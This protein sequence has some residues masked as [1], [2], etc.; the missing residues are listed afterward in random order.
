[1]LDLKDVF[2]A[3]WDRVKPL[4]DANP[5]ERNRRLARRASARLQ[6]PVREWCIA[7]RAND[8]RLTP[9]CAAIVPERAPALLLPHQVYVNARLLRNLSHPVDSGFPHTTLKD[10]AKSLGVRPAVVL[11][12]AK[13]GQI[14]LHR[15]KGFEHKNDRHGG[16][17]FVS[18]ARKSLDPNYLNRHQ[19]PDPVWGTWWHDFALSVPPTFEQ[20]VERIPEWH[21]DVTASRLDTAYPT[22]TDPRDCLT[23]DQPP[24]PRA[25]A[26]DPGTPRRFWGWRWRC[27]ACRQTCRLLFYPV[28]IRLPVCVA[29]YLKR[30]LTRDERDAA[31]PIPTLACAKCHRVRGGLSWASGDAWNHIITLVSAGLLYGHE[32]EI[33][34]FLKRQ[35]KFTAPRRPQNRPS[36]KRNEVEQ[37]LLQNLT[38]PQIARELGISP[39]TVAY[40]ALAAR[41]AHKVQTRE[42]LIRKLKSLQTRSHPKS[43]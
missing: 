25:P 37:L 16:I 40:H 5:L 33:P 22:P 19:G 29:H 18:T 2:L 17:P 1:M 41:K 27:P 4:L 20:I 10:F 8:L 15:I 24:T 30:H 7:L 23:I 14:D 34:S 35:R 32:V 12:K 31:Q 36:P 39:K 38:Y 43:A 11:A 13:L 9:F 3:A 6:R 21:T 42:Q 26:P 28:P